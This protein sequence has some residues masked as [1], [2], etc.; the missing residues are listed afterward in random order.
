MAMDRKLAQ[1]HIVNYRLH[2]FIYSASLFVDI[3]VG[4]EMA[5]WSKWH[6]IGPE[7]QLLPLQPHATK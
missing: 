5:I 4:L 2:S 7:L 6:W 1:Y 3:D